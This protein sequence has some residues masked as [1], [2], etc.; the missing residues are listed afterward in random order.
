MEGFGSGQRF[1]TVLEIHG[2]WVAVQGEPE[3]VRL[4]LEQ[5][6]DVGLSEVCFTGL[7]NDPIWF[8]LAATWKVGVVDR[9]GS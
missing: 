8:G 4:A 3:N 2:G 7:G 9:A 5:A 1:A 6:R